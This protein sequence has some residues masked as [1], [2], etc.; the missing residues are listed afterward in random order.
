MMRTLSYYKKH[1]RIYQVSK[2]LMPVIN[3]L[4]IAVRIDIAACRMKTI[5]PIASW[6][7]LGL[8]EM[9]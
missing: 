9:R 2:I 6:K 1:G 8:E 5:T 4:P 3:R 7:E